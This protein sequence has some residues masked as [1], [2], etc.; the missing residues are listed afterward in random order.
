MKEQ[1]KQSASWQQNMVFIRPGL[2]NGKGKRWMRS[3]QGSLE[4]E[5][6]GSAHMEH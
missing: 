4:D 1:K 6:D 2:R 3:I 5:N